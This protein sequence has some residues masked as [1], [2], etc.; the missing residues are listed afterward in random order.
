MADRVVRACACPDCQIRHDHPDRKLH[1]QINLLMSRLDEQQRRW[2]A[3]L[4]SQKAGD[5]VFA[6]ITG[7]H[8]D[9]IRRG[10][11]E[12]DTDLQGRPTDRVRRPGAGRPSREKKTRSFATTS[13]SSRNR[14]RAAIR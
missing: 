8:V 12:L 9:T 6:L 2:F 3:A 7:L 14:P 4:E 13:S 5:T 1:H 10:R 11:E